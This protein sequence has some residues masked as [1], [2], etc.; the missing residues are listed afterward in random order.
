MLTVHN[1][2]EIV[3]AGTS[4]CVLS[5]KW[6]LPSALGFIFL[7]FEDIICIRNYVPEDI[8]TISTKNTKMLFTKCHVAP[9]Y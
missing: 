3:T 5:S 6:P 8:N 2:G 9:S 1:V 7:L 4:S